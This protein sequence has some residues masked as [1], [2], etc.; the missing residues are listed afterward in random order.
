MR[1]HLRTVSTAL[2]TGLNLAVVAVIMIG[3]QGAHG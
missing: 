2:R 1:D 3:C